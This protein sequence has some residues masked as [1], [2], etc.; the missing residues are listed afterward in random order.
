MTIDTECVQKLIADLEEL[1][2]SLRELN[3]G[4]KKAGSASKKKTVSLEEVRGK[5]AD[6]SR[7][8]KTAA[9]RELIKKH[10][11]SKLSDIDPADYAALLKDAEE[12]ENAG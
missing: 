10:G 1:T 7:A 6:I 4:E 3:A 12:M 2:K 5:L 11:G 8:G 9:V